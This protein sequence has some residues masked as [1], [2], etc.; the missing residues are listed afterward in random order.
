MFNWFKKK[1]TT[2]NQQVISAEVLIRYQYVW[3][4]EIPLDERDT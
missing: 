1:A 3:K 4:D 2:E